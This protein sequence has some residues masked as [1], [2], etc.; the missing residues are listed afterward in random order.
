MVDPFTMKCFVASALGYED[1]DEIFDAAIVPVMK[2]LGIQVHRVDRIEH[3]EDVD[4]RILAL[5]NDCNLCIADLTYARPS[6]YFEAGFVSASGKPVV[7]ICRSDHFKARADDPHG[8]LRVH[9]DLQMKNIIAW[10][11]PNVTFRKRLESRLR[12]VTRPLRREEAARDAKVQAR[13]E[14]QKLANFDNLSRLTQICRTLIHQK[15]LAAATSISSVPFLE[16]SCLV[17]VRELKP[18]IDL[19]AFIVKHTFTKR[20]LAH[21]RYISFHDILDELGIAKIG[22]RLVP[23]SVHVFCCSLRVVP[24]SRIAESL[25]YHTPYK[26]HKTFI[27]HENGPE[28]IRSVNVL[29]G[30][31]SLPEFEQQLGEYLALAVDLVKAL[32]KDMG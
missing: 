31:Q 19:F 7:Y 28:S 5:M 16:T 23:R 18:P 15:K 2:K 1:V 4:D 21:I 29:D 14:F 22:M 8:N 12:Y 13:A 3:N 11:K 20:A 25:P 6:V 26:Q 30:I 27:E 9:F 10:T 17:G 24:T 32:Q